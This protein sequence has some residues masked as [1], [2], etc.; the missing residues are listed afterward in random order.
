MDKSL[1]IEKI[2]KHFGIQDS[3]QKFFFEIF[4][5]K[6]SE[7]LNAGESLLIGE[8]GKIEYRKVLKDE[9]ADMMAII[10]DEDEFVFDIPEEDKEVQ[11]IDSYFSISIGKPVI[12][13]RENDDSEF[14]IP[15]SGNEMKRMFELKVA[16]FIEDSKKQETEK[17]V[18]ESELDFSDNIPD[19]NFSFKNWKSS[20]D[21]DSELAEEKID[22]EEKTENN[23][24]EI[25]IEENNLAEEANV[26]D[27]IEEETVSDFAEEIPE[28]IS[29]EK[30]SQLEEVTPEIV[31]VPKAVEEIKEEIKGEH[32]EDELEP[33]VEQDDNF[34]A[35]F[36]GE[37]SSEEM[38]D[39]LESSDGQLVDEVEDS[40]SDSFSVPEDTSVDD[41]QMVLD[42]AE[43]KDK[44]T[45]N[46]R[47]KS[48]VGFIFVIVLLAVSGAVIYFSSY[49]NQ[50]KAVVEQN[51]FP[52]QFAVTVERTY[53]IPVTY[54]Y[55]KGML[56]EPY[57][58]IGEEILN[59]SGKEEIVPAANI[60]ET[61]SSKDNSGNIEIRSPL[62]ASRIKGYIYKY[63][64]MYA[65]QVSSWK[66][67]SIA[68]SEAK[69]FLDAGYDAFI[70][71]TELNDKGT[72]YRV[73]IGGFNS[74]EEAEN[75]L[76][77]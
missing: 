73:R 12:P 67:K 54:P 69:K 42:A 32:I 3:E 38:E 2:A 75:F 60:N 22:E 63:A 5:R 21:S 61:L 58:A 16:R 52:K 40:Q 26:E 15:H 57:N 56:G 50:N 4:L 17:E 43:E 70:E 59:E 48:Y 20:S 51:N 24:S 29:E 77:K 10:T 66:S 37:E 11:S 13:L 33:D 53:E 8:I 49:N 39:E 27:H 64:N 19:I 68:I 28:Q 18:E 76:N 1:I 34:E 30:E 9:N 35:G 36:P 6:C 45:G 31:E 72:Y 46:H 25:Q 23:L 41:N 62:P 65:V 44:R 71:Q 55:T 74:L 7:A 14:F 47:K